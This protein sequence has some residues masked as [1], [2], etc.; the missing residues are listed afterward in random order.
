MAREHLE[1]RKKW[2]RKAATQEQKAGTLFSIIMGMYLENTEFITAE[3]PE[4][5]KNIYRVR[6]I[7]RSHGIE[8]EFVIRNR[9]NGRTIFVEIN[10]LRAGRNAHER[11]SKYM[12]PDIMKAIQDIANQPRDIIPF[13]WI[14]T[15][16]IASDP[17]YR[18]EI[19]FW[20]QG[21]ENHL[22]LW[23]QVRDR[24]V[25]I[26]HFEQHIRPLLE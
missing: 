15:N 4:D 22:L 16:G 20:F 1:R 5:L 8:L 11:A 12:V 9:N 3:E 2:Q 18:Q 23:K 17:Y 25:V 10:C 19:Q 7:G 6:K 24:K 21:M 13:W 26:D 14:F